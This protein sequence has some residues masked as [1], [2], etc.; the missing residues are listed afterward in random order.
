[1]PDLIVRRRK[2]LARAEE[3]IAQRPVLLRDR[4][5]AD[6]PDRTRPVRLE[7]CGGCSATRGPLAGDSSASCGPIA[8]AIPPL[9][10]ARRATKSLNSRQ[11]LRRLNR[12]PEQDVQNKENV[13]V[14][15][16]LFEGGNGIHE[17]FRHVEKLLGCGCW[18]WDLQADSMEWSS[19]FYD[20]LGVERGSMA[21]SMAALKQLIHPDDRPPQAEIDRVIR[22]ASSIR[23]K[24][25]VIQPSGE[26]V[27]IFCQIRVLVNSDGVSVKAIGVA[28]DVTKYQDSLSPLRIYEERYR[29]IIRAMGSLVWIARADGVV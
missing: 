17:T 10:G 20:L 6:T 14:M 3:V 26:I 8:R 13:A 11:N 22:E 29:A 28:Q 23:R 15:L 9:S 7:L 4:P 18:T 21:G 12:P 16:V 5:Q 19:G 27:W 1:V 2:P 24:F 25:R